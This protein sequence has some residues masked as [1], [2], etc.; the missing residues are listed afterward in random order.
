MD[1]QLPKANLQKCPSLNTASY[2][3]TGEFV[4]LVKKGVIVFSPT[5]K[6]IIYEFNKIITDDLRSIV[7]FDDWVFVIGYDGKC[8]LWDIVEGGFEKVDDLETSFGPVECARWN[9][10][11]ELIVCGNGCERYK[12]DNQKF[13][14]LGPI[15]LQ[16]SEGE[17][18][19]YCLGEGNI[20]V[21]VTSFNRVIKFSNEGVV[22]DL[23]Y[24]KA[25]DDA[26]VNIVYKSDEIGVV[27]RNSVQWKGKLYTDCTNNCL[28]ETA[29]VIDGELICFNSYGETY[30]TNSSNPVVKQMMEAL[31]GKTIYSITMDR[32]GGAV[33]ALYAPGVSTTSSLIA[34]RGVAMLAVPI[35]DI[36]QVVEALRSDGDVTIAASRRD[37][38]LRLHKQRP[39]GPHTPPAVLEDAEGGPYELCPISGRLLDNPNDIAQCV[40]CSARVWAETG[41]GRRRCPFCGSRLKR[42]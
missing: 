36:A 9:Q 10:D 38:L 3:T 40:W 23:K 20:Y 32:S 19:M 18:V 4:F 39:L 12:L 16:L 14:Y 41:A 35:G 37:S 7:A 34:P 5:K 11:S 42:A 26:V 30:S 25:K 31:K 27:F 33:F 1:V 17:K 28:F 13:V 29:D 21:C 2:L 6:E 8:G 24:D 22:E 15:D